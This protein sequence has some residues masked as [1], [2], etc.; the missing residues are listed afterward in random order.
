VFL[1]C[2]LINKILGEEIMKIKSDYNL[3]ALNDEIKDIRNVGEIRFSKLSVY[4]VIRIIDRKPFFYKEH[5]DRLKTSMD[6]A[7]LDMGDIILKIHKSVSDISSQIN[8]K[9]YNIKI[10]IEEI[11]GKL[12]F[13]VLTIKGFYPPIEYYEKGV[14]T[15]SIAEERKNPNAKVIN[16]SLSDR[17]TKMR[18]ETDK[19]EAILINEKGIVTEGSRSNI[20]F[21]KGNDIYTSRAD[22]VLLGIT[23]EQVII[24]I[25]IDNI[26]VLEV[27]I[28]FSELEKFDACFITGTSIDV[29]PVRSIDDMEFDVKNKVLIKAMALYKKRVIDS[30][31][32]F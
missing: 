22:D 1:I 15:I 16:F 2:V 4:E 11:E 21:I 30:L 14:K 9:N 5:M 28:K 18:E 17:V 10:L 29:L 26:N 8:E 20:F 24:S 3:F 13:C 7:G 32:Q 25:Q 23:R 31:N 27:D 12:N 19:F 6:L